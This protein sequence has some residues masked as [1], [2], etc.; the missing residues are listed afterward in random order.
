MALDLKIMASH[1]FNLSIGPT[2]YRLELLEERGIKVP[3]ISLGEV[4]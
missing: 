2:L 4:E 3:S 1:H